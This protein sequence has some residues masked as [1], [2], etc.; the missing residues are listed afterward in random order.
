[1]TLVKRAKKFAVPLNVSVRRE[2]FDRAQ[3][4]Q[5]RWDALRLEQFGKRFRVSDL[6]EIVWNV[7]LDRLERLDREA[8]I[9]TLKSGR[10]SEGDLVAMKCRRVLLDGLNRVELTD[11][12]D[13]LKISRI[14]NKPILRHARDYY[15][16][17]AR[18]YYHF[19]EP[20]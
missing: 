15:I 4:L 9:E 19:R 18:T 16:L 7:G 17:D 13:L 3:K 10:L 6:G 14:V 2:T 5:L 8:I 20:K 1:L 12:L 11:K